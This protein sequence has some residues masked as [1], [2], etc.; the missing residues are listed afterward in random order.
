MRNIQLI[1]LAAALSLPLQGINGQSREEIRDL[2]NQGEM[3]ILYE[4]YNEALPFFLRLHDMF[5]DNAN[6]LFRIGQCYSNIPGQKHLAIPYLEEAVKHITDRYRQGRLREDGAPFDA[7]YFLA[8]A[9]RINNQLDRAIET[10]KLFL[11]NM[12][13]RV[14][15]S[16]IVKHKLQ[17]CYNAKE[18]M[19]SPIFVRETNLGPE[20]NDRFSER[21]PVLSADE[22]MIFFSRDL[23]FR[24]AL[25]YSRLVDGEWTPPIDII[26]EIGVDDRFYP[27]SL[28]ADG[29]TLYL[30]SDHDFVGNI[31]VTHFD[32]E[33][34]GPVEKLNENINTRYWESHAS[35]SSCGTRLYFSSNRRG[36]YGG[37]DI[38]VSEID[39]LGDWGPA[40][41]LGP[42]INT[43]FHDD[44]PFISEDGNRLFFSS[45]GHHNIGGYDIF[46]ADRLP[47]GSW[48]EPVNMGYPL[49]TTDDDL[50]FFPIGEGHRGYIAKFDEQGYGRM[51]IFRLDIYSERNPRFFT[52]KGKAFI[53]DL[54]EGI[55][56]GV[57]VAVTGTGIE[58]PPLT[59]Q[60]NPITGTYQF[61]VIHGDYE[62]AFQA[63]GTLREVKRINIPLTHDSDTFIVER[64][65]LRRADHEALLRLITAPHIRAM[66]GDT[67]RLDIAT[68]PDSRLDITVTHRDEIIDSISRQVFDSLFTFR[69]VPLPGTTIVDFRLTDRLSN[70]AET[71]VV[72]EA[73]EPI[74]EEVVVP[75]EDPRMETDRVAEIIEVLAVRADGR[76]KDIVRLTDPSPR[77]FLTTDDILAEIAERARKEGIPE[78]LTG[79]MAL[80]A[81]FYDDLMSQMAIDFLRDAIPGPPELA[82]ILAATDIERD[83]I[84]TWRDLRRHVETLSKGRV[85]GDLLD[86]VTRWVIEGPDSEIE[87]IR[88]K[89]NIYARITDDP[90][91]ITDLIER[92]D[93]EFIIDAAEWL[94]HFTSLFTD[95]GFTT[96]ELAS[97][98]TAIAIAPGT[99]PQEAA[100]IISRLAEGD[101]RAFIEGLNLRRERITSVTSLFEEL[102]QKRD[103]DY[104]SEE[105]FRTLV[106]LI[107]ESDLDS[108]S[109]EHEEVRRSR[110]YMVLVAAGLGF[111][112]LFLLLFRR[113]RKKREE[114]E[115]GAR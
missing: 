71:E 95:A 85:S 38:Y 16:V 53:E 81:A 9:Y 90:T 107:V 17:A 103:T 63:D 48:S 5:P 79:M 45:R 2:L 26:P 47:D 33:S 104:S 31:Y 59:M 93:S 23:P 96:S 19:Q 115:E 6:Y 52:V 112:I 100:D 54:R 72:I 91:A 8:N 29:K 41:N 113:R 86:R 20:I 55:A 34:W 51:D 64:A 40:K 46:M 18:M 43:P 89:L 80:K 7:L 101:L 73:E 92:T 60:T 87:I 24:T 12:D 50:F 49:N 1:I 56:E 105:L 39:S 10:Y 27:S 57:E 69:L 32:G 97:L 35:I 83:D 30:Y 25:F 42:E 61:R 4:E 37:L 14:Y 22:E 67:V 62:I 75:V 3:F 77:R 94:E 88:E 15:D 11:E 76:L 58:E 44:T 106:R 13:H 109:I 74:I 70:I 110:A 28:S 78:S 111:I 102:L 98:L 66:A 68:E 84:T 99:T 114:E 21:N 108:D 82:E 65:G 36:G